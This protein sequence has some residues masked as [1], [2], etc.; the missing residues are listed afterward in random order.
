MQPFLDYLIKNKEWIF[1]GV[2]VFVLSGLLIFLRFI[3]TRTGR[4]PVADQPSATKGNNSE[5]HTKVPRLWQTILPRRTRYAFTT[6]KTPFIPL[7]T[8]SF[9]FEYGPEGHANALTLKGKPV[10]AD[11]EFTCRVGNLDKAFFGANEYGLNVLQPKF[12]LQARS[13]LERYSLS[14][15]R[16]GRQDVAKEIISLMAPQFEELGFLL[17]S[18]TIGSLDSLETAKA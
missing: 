1:S 13:I 14:K 6:E 16:A 8:Q 5:P 18:V 15:L 17:E 12:V 7:G 10:R 11:I 3:F 2:G 9:S 4:V